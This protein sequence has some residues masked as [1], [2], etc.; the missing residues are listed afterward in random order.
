MADVTT[1][2]VVARRWNPSSEPT[3]LSAPRDAALGD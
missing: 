2:I 3:R 1:Q